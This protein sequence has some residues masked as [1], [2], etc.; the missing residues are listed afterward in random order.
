MARRPFDPKRIRKPATD[1]P[2]AG[3]RGLLTVSQVTAMVAEAIQVALPA[4]V[5]VTGEISNFKRHTSGH[6]YFT[7]KDGYSELSCVLWRSAAGTLAFEP[8]DGLAVIATGGVEVFERAGRYQ[9]Y[10][11]KLE[12]R[13]V[14][15]LELAFRQLCEKLSRE[16]LFD[17]Q[18]KQPL[19]A[20]PSRIALVTSPTGAAITDVLRTLERRYPCVDVLIAPV[21]VQGPEASGEIAAAIR[22]LNAHNAVLGG[23][24]VMIVGRGGG[25]LEDLWAFNEEVVARAIFASR[26]PV[27]SAV[28]H[29]VDV[30]IADLV[31]DVRAATP[32]AAAEL[33]VPVRSEVLADLNAQAARLGRSVGSRVELLTARLGSVRQRSAFCRPFDPVHRREQSV[34]EFE[35]RLHRTLNERLR[36]NRR[37]LDG[38]ETVIQRI[39]PQTHLRHRTVALRDA[40]HRLAWVMSLRLARAERSLSRHAQVLERAS[41]A[42]AMAR[43]ANRLDRA[44]RAWSTALSHRVVL[45]HAHVRRLEERLAAMGYK[46]VLGRGFS[47]TRTRKGHRVVRSPA[48]LRDRQRI[49]TEIAAGEFESEVVNLRQLELFDEPWENGS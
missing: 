35:G 21:R 49:V 29:E 5:H 34:D 16:G 25:S 1:T 27:I 33:A 9:L 24:D 18:S 48:Q 28:G 47:I 44:V 20:Y 39:A 4:T 12:P 14:G 22:R 42:G 26:I 46:S 6:L 3:G 2:R 11:R 32:T 45:G 41:P 40:E 7:L 8:S 23:I 38:L 43:L 30:T 37:R 10:V 15:A 31:A 36:S 17:E 19:A 13:G